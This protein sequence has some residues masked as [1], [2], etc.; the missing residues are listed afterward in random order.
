MIKLENI[1][2]TYIFDD[3]VTKAL[4]DISIHIR[5]GDFIAIMGVSGSG[6][7]T[8][9]NILGCMDTP[10][11]GNYL[12]EN[13]NISK[14]N[15]NQLSK[16]RGNKITFVFQNFALMDKYTAYENIEISL[17]NK[18]DKLRNKKNITE[19]SKKLG[20]ENQ[21]NKYPKQMS[22]GQQQR[23]ALARALVSDAD[24]ILADEPTGALDMKTSIEFMEILKELNNVG[25]TII[26]V[27]HDS[28][29]ADYATNIIKISDGR[30]IL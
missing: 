24:I 27:T 5:K 20:I 25:K 26:L 10:T 2:K 23:V 29:V 15:Q 17:I 11:V 14:Y 18:K 28:M 22:G 19:I 30:L 1:S 13:E 3:I 8:L 21:L 4:D 7:S 16:L 6:K 12:L 9:L